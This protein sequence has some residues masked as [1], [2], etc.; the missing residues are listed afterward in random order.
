MTNSNSSGR[1]L[2]DEKFTNVNRVDTGVLNLSMDL[3]VQQEIELGTIMKNNSKVKSSNTNNIIRG[4]PQNQNQNL[5]LSIVETLQMHKDSFP[6]TTGNS[7]SGGGG[8]KATATTHLQ[9]HHHNIR[10]L[11]NQHLNV[12]NHHNHNHHLLPEDQSYLND[13]E[14]DG[15]QSRDTRQN[16]LPRRKQVG[17]SVYNF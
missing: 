15:N 1:K 2:D 6:T 17:I 9:N 7:G 10:H 12:L 16:L 11:H 4:K 3:K 5:N 13:E 14:G 8:M